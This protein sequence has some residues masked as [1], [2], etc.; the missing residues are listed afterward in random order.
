M[1]LDQS[2]VEANS[3]AA[4][5]PGLF[6]GEQECDVILCTV[7]VVRTW[8]KNI[9]HGPTLEKMTHAMHKLTQIGCDEVV[10]DAIANCPVQANAKYIARNYAGNS[11]KWALWARQHSPLLLQVT[12]T[13]PLESYHSKL[14]TK[15]SRA[16]GLIG[17]GF[18][19]INVDILSLSCHFSL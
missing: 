2:S 19:I 15:I 16:H 6:A 10:K 12:S 3:I 5:F 7:H 1:L 9:Y 11:K 13:N 18:V 8:I 4:T 14:K 17:E